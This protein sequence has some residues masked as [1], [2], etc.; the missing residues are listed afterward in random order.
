M[1][2]SLAFAVTLFCAAQAPQCL[3]QEQQSFKTVMGKGYDIRSVTFAKGEVTENRETFIVTLQ[4]DKSVAV[5][6]FS[7]S[8]WLTLAH[9]ILEDPK[10]CDVR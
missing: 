4:K 1:S 2:R 7:A 8:A 9:N 3:A 10:R 5:C 6:Y